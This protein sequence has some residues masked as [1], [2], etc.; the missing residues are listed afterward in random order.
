MRAQQL[1]SLAAQADSLRGARVLLFGCS[2]AGFPGGDGALEAADLLPQLGV[3]LEYTHARDA[4]ASQ[5][6]AKNYDV[7]IVT[8]TRIAEL[9]QADTRLWS[10]GKQTAL[11]F[12]DLRGGAVGAALRDR[13]GHAFLSFNGPWVSPEGAV[14][15][16]AQW[17]AALGCPVGYAPQASPLREPRPG[18]DAPR[19]VFVGDTANQT[20]H[21][22]RAELCRELGATV[23]N[24]RVREKRLAIEADLPRLY[25]S[26]RYVLSTSPRAPGYT[27]VRTY[28]ILACGGLLLLHRFPGAEKLFVDGEHAVFFD[29]AEELKAKLT[30]L[31]QDPERRAR[32]AL[33]G[34]LLHATRHTL[35]HRVVSIARQVLGC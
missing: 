31:D 35:A 14:F 30:E 29:T 33:A 26:A 25:P 22:G 12:W 7:A 20:Y 34:R 3:Q 10:A 4:L 11:W 18:G 2:G 24:A 5:K 23:V 1:E 21:A 28:S 13:V 32:I 15:E 16:P 6:L 27:S 8:N 17:R 19:V 9:L